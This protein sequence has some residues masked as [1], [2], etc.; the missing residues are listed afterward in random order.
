MTVA[1]QAISAGSTPAA[2]TKL[3]ERKEK[4]RGASGAA[5]FLHKNLY[6]TASFNAFAAR[7]FA[8]REAAM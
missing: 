2:R 3:G 6:L 4:Q 8:V 7:N 5:L 1:F